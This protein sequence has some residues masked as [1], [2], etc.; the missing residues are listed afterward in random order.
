[1]IHIFNI[2]IG[3]QINVGKSLKKKK[4]A[5]RESDPGH[6]NDNPT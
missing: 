1:M 5:G 2:N 4:L 3:N 6:R